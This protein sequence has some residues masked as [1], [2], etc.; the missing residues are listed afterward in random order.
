MTDHLLLERRDLGS[1]P[2]IC[3]R[4]GF[5]QTACDSFHVGPRLLYVYSGLEPADAMEPQPSAAF[6]QKRIAPLTDRRIHVAVAEARNN[7][8]K[9]CGN[10]SDDGV[11][12]SIESDVLSC[13]VGRR[14]EL[15]S[16]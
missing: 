13:N 5:R 1:D 11:V 9:V 16:P 8:V 12:S 14:V 7:H 4:K 6:K 3:I 10:H 2:F 15:A